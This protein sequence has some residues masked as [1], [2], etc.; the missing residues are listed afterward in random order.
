VKFSA[1]NDPI[2]F[3]RLE[4]SVPVFK[5]GKRSS[6]TVG[7][8]CQIDDMWEGIKVYRS[9]S[10]QPNEDGEIVQDS[11]RAALAIFRYSVRKVFNYEGFPKKDPDWVEKFLSNH[12]RRAHAT[13]FG[14]LI[15]ANLMPVGA[16]TEGPLET[17]LD[18]SST[19]SG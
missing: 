4:I 16:A 12:Q 10:F 9:A 19:S 1:T 8:L 14:H 13:M 15:W 17:P 2:V 7:A 3:P 11:D 5:N 18:D 6:A